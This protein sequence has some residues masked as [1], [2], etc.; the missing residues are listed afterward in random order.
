MTQ[1][2][3]P[4]RF[5][6]HLEQLAARQDLGALA[7]LRR[8]LGGQPAALAGMFPYVVP[9]LPRGAPIWQEDLYYQVAALFALRLQSWPAD[10]SGARDFGASFARLAQAGPSE[11]SIERRFVAL[12][13]CHIEELP[14][15]LRHAVSLMRAHSVPVDWA[16]LIRDAQG[17]TWESRAVQRRWARSFWGQAAAAPV[18]ST[19]APSEAA[20]SEPAS[21]EIEEED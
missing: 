8:G 7:A 12:L 9:W 13:A 10:V 15:Q 3:L 14:D 2:D 18:D 17:W 19:P 5:V 11:E 21:S 20:L 6:A 1:T 4:G 16:Q